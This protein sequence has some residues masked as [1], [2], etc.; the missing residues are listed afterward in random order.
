MTPEV[1]HRAR[2]TGRVALGAMTE[3]GRGQRAAFRTAVDAA[4]YAEISSSLAFDDDV[5]AGAL[6]SLSPSPSLPARATGC[7]GGAAGWGL[8]IMAWV[9]TLPTAL[10]ALML[11][12]PDGKPAFCRDVTLSVVSSGLLIPEARR[13]MRRTSGAGHQG[14]SAA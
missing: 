5:D 12:S 2:G 7:G 3:R 13:A 9:I 4:G 11:S 6:W 8:V 14:P 10:I 1:W